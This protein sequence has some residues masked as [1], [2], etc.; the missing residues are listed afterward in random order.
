MKAD[1]AIAT[2]RRLRALPLWR[3]L[4]A[5]NGPITIGLLQTQLYRLN[6]TSGIRNGKL[7]SHGDSTACSAGRG[8]RYRSPIPR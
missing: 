1:K 4:S 7:L 6:R 8:N 2:Y 3:L 5:D